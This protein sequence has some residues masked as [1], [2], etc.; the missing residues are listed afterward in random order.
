ERRRLVRAD[1]HG[2][3]GAGEL[4]ER[5]LDVGQHL[6]LRA[7]DLVVARLEGVADARRHALVLEGA[8]QELVETVADE[9]A[10]P[11]RAQLA[12]AVLPPREVHGLGERGVR[13]DQ[14]PVE[15]EDHRAITKRGSDAHDRERQI[16][17]RIAAASSALMR[18]SLPSSTF[19]QAWELLKPSTSTTSSPPKNCRSS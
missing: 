14:G 11:R 19:G 17:S 9:L 18:R 12:H 13:V 16:L 10:D 2:H 5:R 1:R 3:A 6:R 7:A 8:L 4:R 15:I